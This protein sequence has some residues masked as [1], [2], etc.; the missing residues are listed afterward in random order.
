MTNLRTSA[1]E[2]TCEVVWYKIRE[3]TTKVDVNKRKFHTL[4][5]FSIKKIEYMNNITQIAKRTITK[6]RMQ[7]IISP[8][9][10]TQHQRVLREL[11]GI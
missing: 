11:E 6:N 7:M 8:T 9:R 3:K 1:W 10:L 4:Y 2:A 5:I